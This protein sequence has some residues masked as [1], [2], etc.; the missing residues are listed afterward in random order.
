M[1]VPKPEEC[2]TV[3]NAH[4]GADFG[5]ATQSKRKRPKELIFGR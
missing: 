3:M 2:P 5:D 4:G 1:R